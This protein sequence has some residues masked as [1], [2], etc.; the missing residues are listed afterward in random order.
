[1]ERLKVPDGSE[2]FRVSFSGDK[3][4]VVDGGHTYEIIQENME[5][6]RQLAA[7]VDLET[8]FAQYVRVDVLT[9]IDD[10]MASQIAGGL[11][12]AVQVQ[13]Q[14][15]AELDGKF[16]WLK[17]VVKSKP[18]ASEI[19]YKGNEDKEITVREVLG[20]LDLFNID[21]FPLSEGKHPIRTCASEWRVLDSYLKDQA[22]FEKM[23]QIACDILRLHD[24]IGISIR[25]IR[26]KEKGKGAALA[27]MKKNEKKK[28]R[29]IFKGAE[30]E[31]QPYKG[32]LF[33]IISSFRCFI[34]VDPISGLYKW[35]V[36]FKEILEFWQEIAP[37]LIELTVDTSNTVGRKPDAIA[38]A[39]WH[40][41]TLAATVHSAYMTKYGAKAAGPD[42]VS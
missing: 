39:K 16:E 11:N 20:I 21:E 14:A 35:A 7:D 40:W 26:N 4:G 32:A 33:P 19:A 29:Y 3:G 37:Q 31:C 34:I 13:P 24:E 8:P 28:F 12:T 1:V 10:E 6:L 27:W 23:S 38:K 2:V 5:Q 9:G 42:K 22:R 36:P 41:Q 17:R 30:S 18:Y 25:D 15:L